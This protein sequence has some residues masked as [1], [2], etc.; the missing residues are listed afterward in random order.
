MA[1]QITN[2][3]GDCVRRIARRFEAG[4][5]SYGHGTDNATDEA[6][7]LVF[8]SLGLSH[9]DAPGVYDKIVPAP[10]MTRIDALVSRRIEERIP[11][12][13][14]VKQAFFAG[15]EFYVDERVLIPRSPLAELVRDRFEP[16]IAAESLQ[17]ALDL[18]TGSGCIAIAIAMAFPGVAVD[19]VDISADALDVAAINVER[20]K[21]GDRVQLLQSDFFSALAGRRYDLIVS[22]PPY[23]DQR[24]MHELPAEYRKEPALG[25]ASGPDGL[26]SVTTIL[27]HSARFLRDHGILICE[28]GNSQAALEKC[29]PGV[30]FTWL[31]F[32]HGGQGVFILSKDEVEGLSGVR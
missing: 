29:Y 22:N 26:D 16:W 28:V 14:L 7:W 3:V 6:A 5:L 1:S 31:E 18:G 24:D 8:A 27:H 19:A 17:S 32:E 13:Y 10:E 21:L 2:T 25:L 9:D 4:G 11:T 23:V 30:A 20:H 12:A 15:H